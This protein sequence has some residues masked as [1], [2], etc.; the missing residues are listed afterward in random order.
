M[1][2]LDTAIISPLSIPWSETRGL[3]M[4]EAHRGLFL[5]QTRD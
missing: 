5:K 1:K 4:R 3:I 2:L